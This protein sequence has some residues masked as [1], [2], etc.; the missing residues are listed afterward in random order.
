VAEPSTKS[1]VQKLGIKPGFCILVAGAPVDY[2][3]LVG[4]L[5]ERVTLVGRLRHRR[6][7]VPAF[8]SSRYVAATGDANFGKQRAL[9]NY[10]FQYP[11]VS[12]V[13]VGRVQQATHELRKQGTGRA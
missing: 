3:A 8:R 9:A 12:E 13:R 2:P 5:P 10:R 11:F 7:L 4:A 6:R 1:L